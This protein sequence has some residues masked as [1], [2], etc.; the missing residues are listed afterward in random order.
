MAFKPLWSLDK[1]EPSRCSSS[2]WTRC[3]SD[4]GTTGRIERHCSSSRPDRRVAIQIPLALPTADGLSPCVGSRRL[5]DGHCFRTCQPPYLWFIP[6]IAEKGKGEKGLPRRLRS[7]PPLTKGVCKKEPS[8]CARSHRTRCR[9]EAGTTG[10]K[11]RQ[12]P[13]ARPE[14]RNPSG[15]YSSTDRRSRR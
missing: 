11:E 15:R 13:S 14:R 5:I 6:Y 2:H 9:S 12:S 8:R 3:C 7:A 10:R 1:N 4:S